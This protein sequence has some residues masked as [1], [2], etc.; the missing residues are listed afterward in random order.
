MIQTLA[1]SVFCLAYW[2]V[3]SNGKIGLYRFCHIRIPNDAECSHRP[4]R[5]Y[6]QVPSF[7]NFA[8]IVCKILSEIL[9]MEDKWATIGGSVVAFGHIWDC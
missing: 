6:V 9:K 2:L 7:W 4:A 5:K 8:R 1:P 3:W